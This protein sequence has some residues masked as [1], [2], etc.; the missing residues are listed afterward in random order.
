[1]DHGAEDNFDNTTTTTHVRSSSFGSNTDENCLTAISAQQQEEESSD[2]LELKKEIVIAICRALMV[3]N[4]MQ[5]SI[6]D[7]EDVLT[8]PKG[9]FC[10]SDQSRSDQSLKSLWPKNWRETEK[11]LKKFG[12]KNWPYVSMKVTQVNMM[13]WVLMLIENEVLL[14]LNFRQDH[15][16]VFR[17]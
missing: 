8:F 9:M 6:N 17:C 2:D 15:D 12:Y 5:G 16:L 7:I 11:L 3:V 13:L 10:R 14:P 1:M 4:E